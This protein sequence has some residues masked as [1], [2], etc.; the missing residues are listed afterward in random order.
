MRRGR[1][2]NVME[3]AEY[4]GL[5]PD[6]VRQG[7]KTD[8]LMWKWIDGKRVTTRRWTEEWLNGRS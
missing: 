3:A 8:G 5:E 7:M 6:A 2:L 4:A 1:P